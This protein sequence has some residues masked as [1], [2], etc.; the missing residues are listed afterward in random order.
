MCGNDFLTKLTTSMRIIASI[1]ALGWASTVW[2]QPLDS[3]QRELARNNPELA[4][5]EKLRLAGTLVADQVDDWPDTEFG[6]GLGLLP[7]ETRL[8]PQRLKLSTTQMLPWPGLLDARR[9]QALSRAEVTRL[10]RADQQISLQQLLAEAYYQLYE[11]RQ[12]DGLLAQ[13]IEILDQL[14]GLL[15]ERV[16]AGQGRTTGL[17]RLDLRRQQL[18]QQRAIVANRQDI[19]LATIQQL[20]AASRPIT[21]PDTLVVAMIAATDSIAESFPGLQQL[22]QEQAAARA[23]IRLTERESMPRIGVGLDYFF[24]GQREVADLNNNGRDIILP[25]VMVTV[26]LGGDRYAARTAE[27]EMRIAALDDQYTSRQL[28]LRQKRTQALTRYREALI[29]LDLY[30]QQR[31]LLRATI[32]LEIRALSTGETKLEDIL[33]L[34]QQDLEYQLQTLRAVVATHLAKAAYDATR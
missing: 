22:R 23:T 17:L 4:A 27:Q 11:Y 20:L 9:E 16:A 8:G 5:L 7:T 25:R 26:P 3:L 18:E 30:A 10:K 21:T 12:T 14:R 13:Q 32:D 33:E 6:A 1:I 24:V 2:S 34:Y 29:Q 15:L 28:A 31:Q 19:P